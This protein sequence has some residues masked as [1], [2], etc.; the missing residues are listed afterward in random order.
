MQDNSCHTHDNLSERRSVGKLIFFFLVFMSA[1]ILVECAVLSVEIYVPICILLMLLILIYPTFGKNSPMRLQE[2]LIGIGMLI[3]AALHGV[4]CNDA[5]HFE[6]VLLPILCITALYRESIIIIAQIITV[7]VL[8]GVGMLFRPEL[9]LA[10]LNPDNPLLDFVLKML[11]FSTGAV[12]IIIMIRLNNKQMNISRQHNQNVHNLL[13]LV[14]IKKDDAET[15]DKA[16]SAFLANMSHE[17]RT[18][19]NAICGMAE[20]LEHSELSPLNAEYVSTIKSSAQNLL[21]IINNILDYSKIDAGKMPL[22]SEEYSIATLINDVRHLTNARIADKDIALTIDVSPDLPVGFVG[23]ELRV[24]QILINLLGNAVKFTERG[25]ISLTVD[26]VRLSSE[27]AR[28]VFK[29]SDTGIG[30]K[31]EDK[32]YLFDEFTQ[33]NSRK[34]REIE[35]TGL[36]LAI[37]MRLARLMG[38]GIALDS[39]LG[40]GSTFTVTIEQWIADPSRCADIVP[41]TSRRIYAYEPNNYRRTSVMKLAA[42]FNSGYTEIT[43]IKDAMQLTAAE[44]ADSYL[45]FD[46]KTGI[47]TVAPIAEELKSRG[48]FPVVLISPTDI[49]DE[50]LISNMQ[51]IRRPVTLFSLGSVFRGENLRSRFEK[52]K[53]AKYIY[54]KAELLVVD[55]NATN[56]RVAQG[57]L[58]MYK[59][60]ITL[61]ASGFEALD[62]LEAG[63]RYD[64]IF[65]DH[66]MPKMDGVE[67]TKRIRNMDTEYTKNVPIIALT[68]NAMKGV[69]KTFIDAGMDDFIAKPVEVKLLEKA[70]EKWI[71]PDKKALRIEEAAK[72]QTECSIIIDGVDTATALEKFSGDEDTYR[73]ILTVTY[74]D[75]SKKIR[76]LQEYVDAGDFNAYTI[77]V[78]ALKSVCAS[79][80]AF[81]LSQLAYKHECAGKNGDHRFIENDCATLISEFEQLLSNIRPYINAKDD[82]LPD[83]NAEQLS[84]EELS[85]RLRGAL[86]LIEEFEADAALSSIAEILHTKLTDDNAALIKEVHEY[87]DDFN[88]EGAK[89]KIITILDSLKE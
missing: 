53:A 1:F 57:L 80:G 7:F 71:S 6:I 44:D 22:A 37:S 24:R 5:G 9:I 27:K 17:I 31:E 48:I 49:V 3:L 51:F 67:A 11:I 42:A 79:I 82:I 23:D 54:P 63:N 74:N 66:M 68:A 81:T 40:E 61:A 33:V 16:K 59:C 35:G 25:N 52:K 21:G 56:L 72:P 41:D 86:E 62:L 69:E 45:L 14:E 34:N 58:A 29:V 84:T 20:L 77:E 46:Y 30:I 55:D 4:A 47:E 36:G 13:Q 2:L 39:H 88:Y 73:D 87:I 65:M 76:K 19:M 78:H 83:E 12:A 43:D 18:P 85:E 15:A 32:E 60:K 26:C 28:L 89:G 70:L 10:K 38:G 75:G 50:T 64:I 8:Y